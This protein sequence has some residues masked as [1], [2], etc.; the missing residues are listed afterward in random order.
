MLAIGA[1]RRADG[2]TIGI[3]RIGNFSFET[4]GFLGLSAGSDGQLEVRGFPSWLTLPSYRGLST[5]RRWHFFFAW[6]FVLNGLVYLLHSFAT[7]HAQRDLIPAR[8]QLKTIPHAIS[9]H[10]RLRFPKGEEAKTYNVLQKLAYAGIIFGVLPMTIL[11]G[12][13][14]SP[15]LNAAFPFLLDIFGGRQSART[16]HFIGASLIVLFVLV[17]VVMVFASG[18][19]NNMKS[20]ITG[21]YAIEPMDRTD[22]R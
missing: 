21:R 6:V 11:A 14:M 13:T 4:T 18:F 1:A 17:H 3:T 5:G 22:E 16:L 20:M 2:T 9:E 8:D 7:G 15:A 10:L 19:W 12:L